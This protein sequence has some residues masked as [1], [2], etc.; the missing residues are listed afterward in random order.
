VFGWFAERQ[1]E[2]GEGIGVYT[3]KNGWM[4]VAIVDDFA[5]ELPDCLFA[6]VLCTDRCSWWV[7][8]VFVS[9]ENAQ[10]HVLKTDADP[11]GYLNW[12]VPVS[13]CS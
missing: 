13:R 9:E 10:A 12:V 6:V 8:H 4:E 5:G 2:W 7:D 1:A 3:G 11:W